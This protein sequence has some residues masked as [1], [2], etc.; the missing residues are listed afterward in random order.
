MARNAAGDRP[1]RERTACGA[2]PAHAGAGRH[3]GA[4]C[5][6]LAARHGLVTADSDATPS[7]LS[8]PASADRLPAEAPAFSAL[9][10]RLAAVLHVV[11]PGI[12]ER[13]E[14]QSR[15]VAL[16]ESVEGDRSGADAVAPVV[17]ALAAAL[18]SDGITSDDVVERG[19]AFGRDAFAGGGS[20][21]HALKGLDLAAA[22]VLY[23]VETAIVEESTA[24]AADGVRVSRRIHGLESVSSP[25]ELHSPC[26]SE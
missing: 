13:W 20:L 23:A 10:G 12:T 15:T 18:G 25:K 11:A 5:G 19:L 14:Q 2:A 24:T 4:A 21:H 3:A 8:S 17:E 16:R 22:M 7:S 26:V 1:R 9:R 6:K